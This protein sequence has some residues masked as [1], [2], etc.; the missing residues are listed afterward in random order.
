MLARIPALVLSLLLLQSALPDD[1]P[2]NK[3]SIAIEAL[4]RLKGMDLEANPA[5]KSAVLKILATT[6][7][8]P[9][10]VEIVRDFEIEGQDEE[11]IT[12][13][14]AHPET[15]AGVDAVRLVLASGNTNLV[16]KELSP[17]LVRALSNAAEKKAV[18]LL[19]GLLGNSNDHIAREA[20]RGLAQTQEGA[21]ILLNSAE[22]KR[23]SS[24]LQLVASSELHNARWPAVQAKA[25]KILPPP[26]GQSSESV[27]PIAELVKRAG[28]AIKGEEVFNRPAVG[29]ANCH[30][31]K[32]KGMDF[33][34]GLSE[35]GTKLGKDALYEAILDP[36]AGISFGFEAW[37]IEL[38]SGDEAFGI[39]TS[40]TAEDLAL[41]AQTGIVTKLRKSDIAKRQKMSNS[42]MPSGLQQTM[43]VADLVNLVEYLSSLKKTN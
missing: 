13:A 14:D 9:Q 27:P 8:T 17:A 34:P 32:G 36:S 3:T 11:L 1:A 24:T 10:F 23:L 18:P 30:Q 7:G 5:L 20:V 25:R 16:L 4:N 19:A 39:I 43:T 21:E 42:I 37:Q 26:P 31:V 35:I 29:C 33:G 41:K 22:E 6:K 12:Y 2:P 38:K 40:E 28:D 15:S